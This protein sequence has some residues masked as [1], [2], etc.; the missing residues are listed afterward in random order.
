MKENEKNCL[1]CKYLIPLGASIHYT[2]IVC[3]R[4]GVCTKWE[5]LEDKRNEDHL[6][7]VRVR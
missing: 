1:T 4:D 5:P 6:H 7:R 3:I 2:C